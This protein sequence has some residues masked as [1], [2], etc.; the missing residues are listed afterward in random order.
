MSRSAKD[1]AL[2]N[3]CESEDCKDQ[4][5]ELI[6]LSLDTQSIIGNRHKAKPIDFVLITLS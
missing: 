4:Y 5:S 6:C 2:V 3:V 1:L